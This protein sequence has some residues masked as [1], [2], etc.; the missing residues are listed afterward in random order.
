MGVKPYSQINDPLYGQISL[1]DWERE[2]FMLPEVQRLRDIKHLGLTYLVYPCAKYNRLEHTLGTL[3][4]AKRFL[5]YLSP[6]YPQISVY[7]IHAAILLHDIGQGPFSQAYRDVL[8]RNRDQLTKGHQSI[9][10]RTLRMIQTG[11][12]RTRLT[13][14]IRHAWAADKSD[15]ENELNEICSILAA[16]DFKNPYWGV[17]F[18]PL[19]LDRLEY[20]QRDARYSGVL[21]GKVDVADIY[22][23]ASIFEEDGLHKP[24]VGMDAI[25]S[26]E[27]VVVTRTHLYSR[28]YSHPINRVAQT[29]L[30]RAVESHAKTQPHA[31]RELA[32]KVD[33]ELLFILRN[34]KDYIA[35]QI[36]NRIT[37]NQLYSRPKL[38]RLGDFD[39]KTQEQIQASGDRFANKARDLEDK[40]SN[41]LGA[42]YGEIIL[43]ID[44]PNVR[45]ELEKICILR[46]G[47]P[48]PFSE[49][50]PYSDAAAIAELR[51]WI[52]GIYH[53]QNFQSKDVLRNA[54]QVFKEEGIA[55][56]L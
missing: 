54:E 32:D 35:K 30:V 47:T 26:V 44:R 41:R 2:I 6:N 53:S 46:N 45:P 37:Q 38:L 4:L 48:T 33:G 10:Q 1:D 27:S 21:M 22:R 20:Y 28:V 13:K 17:I 52:F 56:P 16:F 43:D 14:I 15:A 50:S 40:V 5:K 7:R 34:S 55:I 23:E 51:H 31:L 12:L 11:H 18:G 8:T 24:C 39:N 25:A 3:F 19:G 42:R 29:M 49:I 9:K 36:A